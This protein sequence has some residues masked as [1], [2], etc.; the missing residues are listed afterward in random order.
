MAIKNLRKELDEQKKEN[1]KIK[2]SVKFTRINEL[3]V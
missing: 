3:E 2:W 1:E